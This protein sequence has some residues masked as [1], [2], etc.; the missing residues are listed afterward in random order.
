MSGKTIVE[1]SEIERRNIEMACAAL[2]VDYC[3]I[4]DS[5]DYG[6]L[7]EV[8]AGD[9][10][11]YSPAAPDQLIEG[12]DAIVAYVSRIPATLVTQHLACNIRVEAESVEAAH[13]SCRIFLFTADGNARATNDGRKAAEKRRIGVY[14]DRY[15]RAPSGWRIAERR[16]QTLLYT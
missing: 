6:R 11:Y 2:C 10:R 16:G 15:V 12:A 5:K 9:A 4:V 14:R 13:G 8:F 1:L 3:E 7:R